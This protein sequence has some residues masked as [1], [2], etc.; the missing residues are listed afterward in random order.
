MVEGGDKMGASLCLE[1]EVD[2]K[3]LVYPDLNGGRLSLVVKETSS[4]CN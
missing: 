2:T 3:P 4:L 1:L